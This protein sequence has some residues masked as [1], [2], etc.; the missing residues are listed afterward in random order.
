MIIFQKIYLFI[1][2]ISFLNLNEELNLYLKNELTVSN[3]F[4]KLFWYLIDFN[5]ADKKFHLRIY[6]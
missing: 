2:C 4:R 6:K 5:A 1:I 3:F